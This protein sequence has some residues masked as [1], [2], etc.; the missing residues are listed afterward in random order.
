MKN[1]NPTW[2]RNYKN[3]RFNKYPYDA[4]VSFIFKNFKK[5]N[6]NKIKILDL[7]CG[8][9]NNSYFIAKEGFDLYAV[10][11]SKES[12]KLT[13]NK[14][15]FY[16]KKKIIK[17]DFTK[18]PYNKDFF[19]CIVDRQSLGCNKI[20]DIK[21]IINEIYRVLKK[22]GKYLGFYFSLE[23]PQIKFG[24][25]LSYN[26]LGKKIIGGDYSNFSRGD[27]K[28]SGLLHFFSER[29]I[30]LLFEKFKK[31]NVLK[32]IEKKIKNKKLEEIVSTTFVV[33]VTK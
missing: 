24:N 4:V 32:N 22:G 15:N 1:K 19:N 31:V 21:K 18:L 26:K 13:R 16:D 28:K 6:R 14:L 23:H 3:K 7:G 25:L 5:K 27:F 11:G 9:G 2:E 8:G 17:S 10:D 12:I 33:E 29:E 30:F 20:N